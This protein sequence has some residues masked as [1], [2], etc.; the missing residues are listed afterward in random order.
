M[1]FRS[2]ATCIALVATSLCC[3]AGSARGQGTD[4]TE[5]WVGSEWELYARALALRGVIGGEPWSIRPFAPSVTRAWASS[6]RDH[7]WASRLAQSADTSRS[8]VLLRPSV[9]SSYNSGFAWGMNDGPVWQG[10]GAN[11]WVTGGFTFH[12]GPLNMRVEPLFDYAENRAFALEPT[13]STASKFAD[14]MRPFTIDEPQRLGDGTVRFVNPGQ[15]FIR[16][17]V[18]GI[19]VGL[20]T[21]DIFWGPGVRNAIL[22]DANASGFPHAFFGTTHVVH[23]PV[24]GFSAQLIY[25]RLTESAWAPPSTSNVRFGA[26]AIAVLMPT[27][28]IEIGAARFYHRD[29]T[30]RFGTTEILAPFGSFFNNTQT[31]QDPDNQLLSI[32]ASVR[33]PSSGFEVFGEFGKNDR[34]SSVRDAL[35]EPE[36]NSAWL[37]GFFDVIGPTSLAEGFW[38]IRAEAASAR[39]SAIQ[40][41]GRGQSTFY[42]HTFLTQGHTEDGQLLGTPL[43]DQ[44]GGIDAALDRWTAAGRVGLS[45]FE[46]Q[47]PG[48]LGVGLPANQL[49]TQWDVG[50]NATRFVGRFDVSGAIGRVWDL[51]RFP[52]TDVGNNYV[53]VS[54]RAGWP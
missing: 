26:G 46:R 44:S 20:S 49:R 34:N 31:V 22:F 29:W 50:V 53:R 43:I 27:P 11:A 37:I 54:L 30:G 12:A 23:T 17:D 8:F 39:V 48:D 3:V 6:A 38:T 40:Q 36:H 33:V 35:A 13:P 24:G 4:W 9:S 25:G 16:L 32:F 1:R 52:G 14:D 2:A 51:N 41:I 42:D 47:M 45:V 28:S 21:E 18:H 5:T 19:A 10:R 15:S 7:P